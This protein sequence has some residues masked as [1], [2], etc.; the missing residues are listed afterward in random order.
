MQPV[1]TL[2]TDFGLEDAYVAAMKGVILARLPGATLVDVCHQVPPGDVLRGALVLDAA[3]RF[4][5]AGCV[6][7][8]V[9]D[10]GVGTDRDLLVARA[11][12][13]TWLA[14]D[15]GLLSCVLQRHPG[16][17]V[18]R[19][20][21]RSAFALPQVSHTFH[22]RDLLA[23]LA[24]G[25]AGGSLDPDG[26]SA[27]TRP[28]LLEGLVAQR[29][30]GRVQGRVLYADHFGNLATNVSQEDVEAVFGAGRFAVRLGERGLG[31]LLDNYQAGRGLEL[32]PLWG[33]QGLLEL[34]RTGAP[35]PL[36]PAQ[37]GPVV[38]TRKDE[39]E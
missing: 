31:P 34:A 12:G 39:V 38:L 30:A 14:P 20:T 27:P 11:A 15:N 26:F 2:T 7:L 13:S 4:F 10:P 24:A 1:I 16:A 36:G 17:E 9:V 35:V 33:S 28:V 18:R 6:H 37:W 22:G 5:P 8:A 19:V 3:T 32:F 25:L 23:P 29:G 21:D